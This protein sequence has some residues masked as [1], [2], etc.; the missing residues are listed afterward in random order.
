L[1]LTELAKL[2]PADFLPGELRAAATV[3]AAF[4]ET[5][6]VLVTWKRASRGKGTTSVCAVREARPVGKRILLRLRTLTSVPQKTITT[7]ASSI[8][9]SRPFS[10]E[11]LRNLTSGRVNSGRGESVLSSEEDDGSQ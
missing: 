7:Y 1:T 5:G 2:D 8:A 9:Q 10:R 11:E 3:L 4:E 6:I